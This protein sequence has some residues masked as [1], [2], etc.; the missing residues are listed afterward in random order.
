MAEARRWHDWDGVSV[1]WALTAE[2]NR[3]AKRRAKPFT[4][5]DVHP[6]MRAAKEKPR[7]ISELGRELNG[8]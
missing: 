5:A 1:L 7:P 2:I 6:Y 4:P 3:D 8:G